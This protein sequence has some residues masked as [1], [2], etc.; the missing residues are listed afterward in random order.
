MTNNNKET[1]QEALT[2][3]AIADSYAHR[4]E[5]AES[6]DTLFDDAMCDLK[7][8]AA[9]LLEVLRELNTRE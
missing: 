5:G 6:V 4:V 9:Q 3:I 7:H 8:L 1:V 2:L